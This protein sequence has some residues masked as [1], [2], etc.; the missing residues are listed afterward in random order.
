MK[1]AL[2]ITT[3]VV[4]ILFLTIL[5]IPILFKTQIRDAV[6]D[7][8][9]ESVNAE[10]VWDS[11][12]FS[13]SLLR[14]FPNATAGLSE[15]G[16]VNRAPFEG[17]VLFAAENIEVEIDLFSL[18]GD[19]IKIKGVTVQDPRI[20]LIVN[21][22]GVANYD[23]A[24]ATEEET[25]PSE[26][27]S[28]SAAISIDHWE[29]QNGYLVYEDQTIPFSMELKNVQH[30]GS[31]NLESDIFDLTTYTFSDSVSVSF[32]N[33]EYIS[34]KKLEADVVMTIS[35]DY[36]TYDFKENYFKVNELNL[37]MDGRISMP[38]E[39]IDMDLTITALDNSFKSLLSLV[40]GIYTEQFSS[41]ESEGVLD[42]TAHIKGVMDSTSNPA[43]DLNLVTNNAMF[44][45]PD[46]PKAV[47]N[48]SIDLSVMNTDGQVENTRIDL[49]N[50]H[51]E[52]G[53]NPFDAKL[54]LENLRDYR[55][56]A[57]L[58]A[59]LN[60]EEITSVF[61]MDGMTLRGLADLDFQAKGVYD[62][63][64]EIMPE[65]N[66]KIL[67]QNGYVRSEEL[68]YALEEL[69]L[70]AS[71]VNP[72]GKMQDFVAGINNF[73]M[74]MDEAPFTL[75]GEVRNLVN[76]AWNLDAVGKLDLS[77]LVGIMDLENMTLAGLLNADVHTRGNLEALEAERYLE[78]PTS[79]NMT[80]TNFVYSDKELPYNVTISEAAA[81]F[82]PEFMELQ[83]FNGTVGRSD[84]A[85]KGRVSN[86][87]GYV[88]G[89]NQVIKGNLDVKSK[90]LDLNEFMTEE[91]DSPT[92]VSSDSVTTVIPVPENID[93]QVTASLAQVQVL[94]L[95]MTN[96][97]GSLSVKDQT[98]NLEDFNF[99][100][101]GGEFGVKGLY[102]TADMNNPRY[103]FGLDVENVSIAQSFKAFDMVRKFAPIAELLTGTFSADFSLN[104]LLNEDMSARLNTVDAEGM[105]EI[106]QATLQNSDILQKVSSLT[107]LNTPSEVSLT[108]VLMAFEINDGKLLVNPFNF[109]LGGYPTTVQGATSID[110][111]IAY[112]MTMNVPAGKLGSTLSGFLSQAGVSKTSGDDEVIPISLGLGGTYKNPEAKLLMDDQKKA[113]TDALKEEA[114]EEVKDKATD[115]L[116]NLLGTKKPADTLATDS[117]KQD[118]TQV[119]VKEEATKI[120]N[121]LFKKKKKKENDQ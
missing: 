108:D 50:L 15:L 100:M 97:M 6:N 86:Y 38:A 117:L 82:N 5:L 1:K 36:S 75:K 4:F 23:I 81:T 91:E 35:D 114:K 14:N 96:A 103:N 85:A 11:D 102:S 79:G 18:F 121:D 9:A 53:N 88:F 80:L 59:N 54:V 61:P 52:F 101:L 109:S 116:N 21:K 25:T 46:L 47:K 92:T 8:I 63:V 45:Y 39:A 106:M 42:L 105:L 78:L 26:P 77:K 94:D 74:V 84:F 70:D 16:I 115:L 64:A 33:T 12:N 62:S 13:L 98:L 30:S 57:T 41:I 55:M 89:E 22:E 2:I 19:E 99:N 66:G 113:V 120:I 58:K 28:T 29:I 32:D 83:Q 76:Y 40:P 34:N 20:H 31:G 110:G 111:S 93:F 60:L 69:V 104:G 95:D 7:A 17:Q 107:S 71:I 3:I 67:F 24:I 56:D 49:K 118:S 27:A 87:M 65:I 43:F 73:S 72:T 90:F 44:K 112:A 37:G 48:I 10:V 51:F 68:P 119:D